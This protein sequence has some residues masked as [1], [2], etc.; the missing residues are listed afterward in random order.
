MQRGMNSINK[1][2]DKHWKKNLSQYHIFHHKSHT[3]YPE[4]NTGLRC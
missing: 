4:E 3:E 1:G 2:N